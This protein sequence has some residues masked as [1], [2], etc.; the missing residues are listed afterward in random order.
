MESG[1]MVFALYVIM[2]VYVIL[3][4]RKDLRGKP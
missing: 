3:G 2:C 1:I 4:V